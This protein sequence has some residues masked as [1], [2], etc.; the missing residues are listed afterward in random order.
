M[1]KHTYIYICR[2]SFNLL[3][4]TWAAPSRRE[5]LSGKLSALGG[6]EIPQSAK[7]EAELQLQH[8]TGRP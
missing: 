8:F 1:D 7:A 2:I 4:V 5:V 3:A 6:V